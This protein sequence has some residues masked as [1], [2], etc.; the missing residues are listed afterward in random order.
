MEII[1]AFKPT[2]GY[3]ADA[4]QNSFRQKRQEMQ[5][6][7]E[8]DQELANRDRQ[9]GLLQYWKQKNFE[10]QQAWQDFNIRDR[11]ADNL[12]DK[13]Y[14]EASLLEKRNRLEFD[15]N[16]E[17]YDRDQ[18]KR[19]GILDQNKFN[20]SVRHNKAMENNS[21]QKGNKKTFSSAIA[22]EIAEI[23]N[24]DGESSAYDVDKGFEKIKLEAFKNNGRAYSF[25]SN[26]IK[27]YGRYP[28]PAELAKEAQKHL[29]GGGISD[30]D[31]MD[32]DNFLN[33]YEQIQDKLQPKKEESGFLGI[34]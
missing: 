11:E 21:S 24:V 23:N 17:S 20:E 16:K 27:Q 10:Q 30:Q 25:V 19:K 18:D 7:R 31:A 33:Y 34:F 12:R 9:E 2:V 22:K 5:R 1:M 32:I 6:Q 15:R 4:F 29:N 3:I 13:E 28:R 14:K 8:I 26:I